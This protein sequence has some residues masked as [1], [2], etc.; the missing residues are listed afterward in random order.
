MTGSSSAPASDDLGSLT[1]EVACLR[2]RVEHDFG[3][4]RAELESVADRVGEPAALLA[5][6][7]ATFAGLVRDVEPAAS[8]GQHAQ[9]LVCWEPEVVTAYLRAAWRLDTDR[10]R[11]LQASWRAAGLIRVDAAEGITCVVA[12]GGARSELVCVT[13]EIFARF[14]LPVQS[15]VAAFEDIGLDDD[16][17]ELSRAYEALRAS[18]QRFRSVAESANDAIISADG[19]GNIVSWNKGAQAIF[20]Y[21]EADAL[22]KPLAL[23]IPERFR[24]AHEAGIKRM[25]TTGESRVIGN[26]VELWGLR[27]DDTEF[28]AGALAG[29][30]DG[31]RRSLLQWHHPRYH[32]PQAHRGGAARAERAR[33][34]APGRRGGLQRGTHGRRRAAGLPG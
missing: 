29:E 31:R 9:R 2:Q 34:V 5:H 32:R 25:S 30:L 14:G 16:A 6:A 11:A 4:M 22:G 17:A 26:T 8:I 10:A 21:A 28:P 1:R 20:G 27:S 23:V 13:P 3:Q 7:G 19:T 18:E 33:A 15:P 12:L 24:A